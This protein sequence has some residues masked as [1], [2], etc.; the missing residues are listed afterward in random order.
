MKEWKRIFCLAAVLVLLLSLTPPARAAYSEE[1]LEGRTWEELVQGLLEEYGLRE[2]QVAMG[3]LNTVTGETH[4]VRGDAYMVTA[5]MYKVPINMVFTERISKGEMDW[6]TVISGYTYEQILEKTII[7]SD[8]DAA[9]KLCMTNESETADN[10]CSPRRDKNTL[11]TKLYSPCTSREAM[12][13]NAIRSSS[14]PSGRYCRSSIFFSP[15]R[16]AI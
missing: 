5:S 10:A 9:E 2:D 11:S 16:F 4:Y 15:V 7:E 12:I 1:D 14:L 13:G 8:N 3:Y 6:D